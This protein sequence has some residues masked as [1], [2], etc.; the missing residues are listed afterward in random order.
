VRAL[1]QEQQQRGLD[2]ALDARPHLPVTRTN[3]VPAANA[4]RAA[5]SAHVEQYR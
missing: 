2:E 4:S 3:L 1:T 5:M